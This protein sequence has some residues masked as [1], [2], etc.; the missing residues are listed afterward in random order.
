MSFSPAIYH[1]AK[2]DSKV[3][4]LKTFKS[5][6]FKIEYTRY[7][8]KQTLKTFDTFSFEKTEIESFFSYVKFLLF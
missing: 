7:L 4:L 6:I 2:T 1:L 8:S 5:I 3:T